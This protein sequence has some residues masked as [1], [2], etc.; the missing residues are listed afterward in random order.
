MRIFVAGAT[1]VIG[2]RLVPRLI[3]EGHEVIGTTRDL[4]R[5]EDLAGAG[6]A[7]AVV[8]ALDAAA[9][10]GSIVTARPD[11]VINQ[12]TALP[13][14]FSDPREGARAAKATN[15]LR[16]EASKTIMAAAAAAG[17][18]RVV[19]QSI[20]FVL[21]PGTDVRNEDDPLY[22]DAPAAHGAVVRAVA[23][24]ERA[25]LE[26][27]VPGVVLRYGAIYGAGT[28][29]APDGGYVEM[30]VRRRL[31]IIG[32]GRGMQSHLH[33]DDCIDATVRALEVA[34]GVY[35][36]VDE[37]PAAATEWI[38]LLAELAGAKPP[39]RVPRL[40]FSLGPLTVLRYLI[41]EQPPVS[42]ERFRSTA[43]WTPRHGDWRA[44]LTALFTS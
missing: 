38:P 28:Y 23:D 18:S 25:T 22:T 26:G 1:G 11:V 43:G 33:I 9:L 2:R 34:P 41:D 15:R 35:N 40:L 32:A 30:I 7:V 3:D 24:L 8:D 36:V 17:S 5:A 44:G 13:Q 14:S 31:P 6:M 29:F 10:R 27:D 42:G 16:S 12:L 4:R 21:R 37:A 20:S 19:A 39:R